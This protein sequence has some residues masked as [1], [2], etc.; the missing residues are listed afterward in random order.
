MGC[1][2]GDEKA[3]AAASGAGEPAVLTKGDGER[4]G[5]GGRPARGRDGGGA[6]P[7]RGGGHALVGV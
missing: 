2:H 6:A 5:G 3:A 7:L 4:E 1:G